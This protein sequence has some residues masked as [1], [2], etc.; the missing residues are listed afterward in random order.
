MS[1]RIQKKSV[2][3]ILHILR[4]KNSYCWSFQSTKSVDKIL[5]ANFSSQQFVLR[6][7]LSFIKRI[8]IQEQR[9]SHRW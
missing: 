4:L 8:D 1:F 7:L 2:E 9:L 3:Q 6:Y 5:T